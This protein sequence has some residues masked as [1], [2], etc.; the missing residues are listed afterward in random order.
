MNSIHII[1]GY[2]SWGKKIALFCKKNKLFKKIIVFT[3]KQQFQYFPK[4]KKI[5]KEELKS[6]FL[7]SSSV[8]ICSSDNSHLKLLNK[9]YKL[10]K[11]II[12]EKPFFAND[13]EYQSSKNNFENKYNSKLYRFI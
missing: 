9:F 1:A 13:K 6:Y 8:H 2:G 11:N 12:V 7:K 5:S 3:R 10:N 4:L